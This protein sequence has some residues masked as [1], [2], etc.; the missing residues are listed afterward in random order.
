M[1]SSRSVQG[2]DSCGLRSCSA[3]T[4]SRERGACRHGGAPWRRTTNPGLWTLPP[5]T[6][7]WTDLR[8]NPRGPSAHSPLEN[9]AR[10]PQRLACAR[11]RPRAHAQRPQA[12]LPPIS[13]QRQRHGPRRPRQERPANTPTAFVQCLQKRTE[14]QD[15]APHSPHA[16][17]SAPGAGGCVARTRR[18]ATRSCSAPPVPAAVPPG[19]PGRAVPH[20]RHTAG[21]RRPCRARAARPR[22]AGAW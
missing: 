14:T 9:A 2:L 1:D 22:A 19:D 17:T 5:L 16:A 18:S 20:A 15:G 13:V 8:S 10:F 11:Q 4:G 21:T 3:N 6:G 7:P 12:P